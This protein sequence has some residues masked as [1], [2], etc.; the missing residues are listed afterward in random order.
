M[1]KTGIPL[2]GVYIYIYIGLK[3]KKLNS[4]HQCAILARSMVQASSIEKVVQRVDTPEAMSDLK[5]INISQSKGW[6]A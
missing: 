1:I 5:T 3:K 4:F 2:Y 6:S